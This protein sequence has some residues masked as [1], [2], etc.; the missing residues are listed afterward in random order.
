[1]GDEQ[2][3]AERRC[4]NIPGVSQ[5]TVQSLQRMLHYNNVLVRSFK[6]AIDQ[7]PSDDLFVVVIRA[8]RRPAG[9]HE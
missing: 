2:V 1:M 3:E 4:D 6:T 7:W 5:N 9:E 8:D